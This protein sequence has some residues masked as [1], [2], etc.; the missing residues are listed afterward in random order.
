MTRLFQSPS[1]KF[2]F[3]FSV[4]VYLDHVT[5][6]ATSVAEVRE[7]SE[8]Q[9]GVD[10]DCHSPLLC[11]VFLSVE[12]RRD[13]NGGSSGSVRK[14]ASRSMG[15]GYSVFVR[16]G[17]RTSVNDDVRSRIGN[18][19]IGNATVFA[20]SLVQAL[21]GKGVLDGCSFQVD[22]VAKAIVIGSVV[23]A[24]GCF[25]TDDAAC[26]GFSRLPDCH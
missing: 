5:T 13:S 19:S 15:A 17:V 18:M 23:T 7:Y 26:L 22:D 9:V 24:R 6:L 21:S 20:Q 4:L 14:S 10:A 2:V 25:S 12:E 1:W 3:S 16:D 11:R 8:V